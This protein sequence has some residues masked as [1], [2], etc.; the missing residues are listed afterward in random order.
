MNARKYFW[1]VKGIRWLLI[2]VGGILHILK[3]FLDIF[4]IFS[5]H[6]QDAVT[7]TFLK[8]SELREFWKNSHVNITITSISDVPAVVVMS[9]SLQQKKFS[10]DSVNLVTSMTSWASDLSN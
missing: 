3:C 5:G 4:K 1:E 7:V 6:L 8:S 10:R 2:F 9:L